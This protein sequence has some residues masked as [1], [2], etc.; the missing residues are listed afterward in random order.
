MRWLDGRGERAVGP[1]VGVDELRARLDRELPGE[2]TDAVTIVDDLA[3]DVEGGLMGN[4]AGRFFAWVMGGA[5]PAA[6][7]ADWLVSAWDQN[8]AI[9]A[10]APAMAVVEEVAGAWM[11]DLL[12]LPPEASFGF[13]SGCQMAHLTALAAARRR[14]LLDRGWDPERQGLRGGPPLRVLSGDHGHETVDRVVQLLG[15]GTDDVHRV[16]T[17]GGRMDPAALAD[18]LRAA[19]E[20]PV[21][22]CLS[23]GDIHGGRFDDFDAL[24][25]LCHRRAGTW[26]HVDGA[27]GLWARVSDRHRRHLDGVEAADSW[28]TDGHKWLNTTFDAGFVAIRDREAH[29]GALATDAPYISDGGARDQVFW[30][31]EWSRRARAVPVYA[32]IRGFGRSGIAEMVDRCC[33]AAER[34]VSGLGAEPGGEVVLPACTNQGLVRFLDPSGEDHDAF[35]ERV[36]AA[37]Q[38]DGT[39]FFSGMSWRGMSVMRVSVVGWTTTPEDAEATLA[40]AASVLRELS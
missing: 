30:N 36:V 19:G 25:P 31:P 11:L 40:A 7:A 24:V 2:P 34:I 1:T 18:Q 27:F 16:A 9:A 29:R 39:A 14:L 12:E 17:E 6:I 21:I 35:T 38:A 33:D 26:V 15:I 8:A 32:A 10:T 4:N 3:R 22:V 13:T 23:A 5:H 37:L 20:E 28:A